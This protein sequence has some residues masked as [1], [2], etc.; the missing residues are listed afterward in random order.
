MRFGILLPTRRL[1]MEGG[2]PEAFRQVIDLAQTAE[3]AG[4]DS[5]WV[6][7]SLT[8]KPRLEPLTD[9]YRRGVP[10]RAGKVRDCGVTASA[11]TSGPPRTPGGDT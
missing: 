1:V 8:A 11:E 7:D 10:Y 2:K 3:R 6:G 5:V 9:T 4:L